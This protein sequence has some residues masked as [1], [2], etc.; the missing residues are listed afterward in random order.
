MYCT[1]LSTGLHRTGL[2][3]FFSPVNAPRL[4]QLE[5]F[6]REAMHFHTI[7]TAF[8]NTQLLVVAWH[9]FTKELNLAQV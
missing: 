5:L 7:V 6:L 9:K 2:R 3:R 4:R 8:M 1:A